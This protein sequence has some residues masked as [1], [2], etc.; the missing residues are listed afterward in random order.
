MGK[1]KNLLIFTLTIEGINAVLGRFKEG[2]VMHPKDL[3]FV[4]IQK[5]EHFHN[6]YYVVMS[7]CSFPRVKEGDKIPDGHVVVIDYT[8]GKVLTFRRVKD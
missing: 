8:Y 6:M 3:K 2:I 7:S 4:R 1:V 5:A